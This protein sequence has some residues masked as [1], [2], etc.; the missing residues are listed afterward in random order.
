MHVNKKRK[1][2]AE[3]RAAAEK[4][5]AAAMQMLTPAWNFAH[6]KGVC[7]VCMIY[8]A[9]KIVEDAEKRGEI[10]HGLHKPAELADL[11]VLMDSGT[12]Q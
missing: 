6:V 3:K 5:M 8:A 1:A 11:M 2:K 4:T 9:G 12:I 7:P 10:T